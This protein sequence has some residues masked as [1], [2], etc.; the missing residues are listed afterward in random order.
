MNVSNLK[1]C[2][3][4]EFTEA[5]PTYSKPTDFN[6]L[7]HYIKHGPIQQKDGFV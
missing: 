5:D 2:N 3:C 4:T 7:N 6:L 1:L